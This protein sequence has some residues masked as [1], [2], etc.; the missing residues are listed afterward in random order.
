MSSAFYVSEGGRFVSSELTRGPWNPDTQHA[1]PPAALIGRALEQLPVTP[2]ESR[3]GAPGS[4]QAW[5]IGRITFEILR[6]VPIAPL[7]VEAEV[8]RPGRSVELLAAIAARRIRRTAD[9]RFGL[10]ARRA[11]A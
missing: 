3:P 1:G 5:F 9:P 4:E 8:V 7:T 2:S 10:A 6:P 11:A